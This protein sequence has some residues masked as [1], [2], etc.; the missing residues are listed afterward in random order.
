[1]VYVLLSLS[2]ALLMIPS[3]PFVLGGAIAF[4]DMPV[5]VWFISVAGVVVGALLVYSFPS[6]GGYDRF[7]EE[8]FP[9]KVVFL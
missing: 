7:L 8:K 1:L 3:T 6:F 4:P 9:D 2:R 5:V